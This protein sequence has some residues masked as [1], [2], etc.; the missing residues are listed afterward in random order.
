MH[1]VLVISPH[2]DDE[3]IGCGGTVRKHVLDGDSV[4][5]AI[6]TSGEKGGHGNAGE[7]ETAARREVEARVAAEIL[8]V[9][10]VEFYRQKDGGLRANKRLIE[11]IAEQINTW[12]PHIIYVP[13]PAE[14]HPDHRAALRLLQRALG[15]A[16]HSPPPRVLAYEIWTPLQRLDEIVD[17]TP[18]LDTKLQAI[19]AYNSQCSVMDFVAA[20]QGLA[21]YRGEMHSWPGGKYAEVFADFSDGRPRRG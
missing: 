16:K 4:R 13:H 6:L 5:V 2:P 10:H 11:I 7:S 18:Y 21:R 15:V 19:A 12:K 17:I 3:S 9:E 20:A 14:Q 8:G 1:R